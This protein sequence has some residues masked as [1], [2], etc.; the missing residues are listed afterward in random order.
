MIMEA[1]K[2]QVILKRY[3]KQQLEPSSD[4]EEWKNSQAIGEFLG[5]FKEATKAFST[6]RTPTSHMF[7][8]NVLCIHQTLKNIK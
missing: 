2:Y 3:A 5:A 1:I 7:L 4:D 6:H 8:H